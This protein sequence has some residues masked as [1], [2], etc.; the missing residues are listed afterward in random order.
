MHVIMSSIRALFSAPFYGL[1]HRDFHQLVATMPLT[2][3]ILFLIMHSV[4]KLGKWHRLPVFL[5]LI[6]LAIRRT[7]QQTYNL[8]NVGPTPVGISFNPVDYPYRTS[9]GKFNDPFNE[10]AGSQGSFFGRNLQPVHQ[11]DKLMKPD[12]VV[13]ATKLLARTEFKDTGKQ[14][15]M[16][17][18]S[19]IQFMIH[20]WVDHLEDTQQIELIAPSEVASE[21][22]CPLKSFK[23]YKTK[24]VPTDVNGIDIGHF[25][26]RTSWWDGSA[27]Y[28]S[29]KNTLLKVRTYKNGKLKI[30]EDSGLLPLDEDGVV[31][32][33]DVRNSWAGVSVLQALFVK[34][35]NAVCD[36]LKREYGD[37]NDEDLYRH[38]RLVTSAVIAKVHTIDWTVELLK[39]DTLLAAMR[40]NW[41][42]LLG[43]KFK[44][45]FGH[46]GG[47]ILGGLVGLPSPQNHGVP[48]SLTEEFTSVY[49]MHALLPDNLLLRD[50]S[51]APGPNKLPPLDEE[52]PMAEMIGLRGERET[53]LLQIGFE[54][55]MVSMGYQPSGALELFNYPK[56]LRDLIPQDIDGK[57]RT[58]HVDLAALEIYR[59]RERKVARY[60]EFRRGL[61]LIPITNWEDLT[62]DA[63][64]I[65][66]LREVYGDNVEDLDLLVGIMAEKKIPGFAISE[67]AFHIFTVMATRRLEADRFFTSYFNKETYTKK[68]LEWVNTTENMKDVLQRHHPEMLTTWMN[69]S[70]VFTVW[71]SPPPSHNPVPLYLRFPN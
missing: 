36:A 28:G 7:L 69:S 47:A 12:P 63:E 62:D 57:E 45:A 61:M 23:F 14:F 3:K 54:K 9:D 1:I 56:F 40:A 10:V 51:A 68:G 71:D 21:Y 38:A 64:A 2:D 17:A 39:T 44:D 18:V 49:R 55:Q 34:E 33:G 70:S 52:V 25:N 65:K 11:N 6:Y 15:N 29:N 30:S 26:I 19:W 59:D 42:G 24:E 5:G 13:V 8:I 4:D 60:N 32:S 41:Y 53:R 48:Y 50:I 22:Q 27:I 31:V 46:V 58:D 43:K 16:I 35:H 67:T 66:T 37:L 20:D